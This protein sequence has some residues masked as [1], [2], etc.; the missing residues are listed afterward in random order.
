MI[1]IVLF[2]PEIPANTGNI[3]RTCVVFNCKLHLI[4]P[5]GFSLDEKHL[6]RSG[7]DYIKDLEYFT[8]PNWQGFYDN[9]SQG[10]YIYFT[11]YGFKHLGELKL[12]HHC[13]EEDLYL[14]FGK[15]STGIDKG[16]LVEHLDECYRIPMDAKARSL[17]LSNC[18]ALG[19]YEVLRQL[20]FP[21]LSTKEVIKGEDFLIHQQEIKND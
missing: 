4:E 1:N 14:V 2:E 5:L 8:Y 10:R 15:E 3:M 7:M 13:Q 16:I 20:N 6:R 21:N 17:N 19:T 9:H 12:E 18:V 11:R